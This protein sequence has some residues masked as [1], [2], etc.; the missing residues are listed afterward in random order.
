MVKGAW[1]KKI[2]V[3]LGFASPGKTRKASPPRS[4]AGKAGNSDATAT[5][6]EDGE[7]P[8]LKSK[9]GVGNLDS[10]RQGR[11]PFDSRERELLNRIT[12]RVE[13]GD[14]DLPHLPA[15]G[16]ALA[17][18]AGKP[19]VEIGRV[20]ELISSD[21]SLASELLRTA[22]SVLYATHVPAETLNEAVMR[23]G[24]RGLR[25]MIFSVSVKG[26]MLRVR[27]LEAYSQEIWRQAYSVAS[28]ARRI[29]PL[30]GI[31]KEHAFL[32]GLLHDVG[33]IVLLSMLSKEAKEFGSA[34]PATVGAVFHV[35]HER[36]GRML[37]ERWR[38]S[39]EIISVA[40][41]HHHF[42]ENVDYGHSAALASLSHKLDLHLS[43]DDD[44]GYRA[45]V[46]CD[47]FDYLGVPEGRR[48]AVLEQARRCF[49]DTTSEA[50]GEDP[51]EARA[52]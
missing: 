34:S 2:A 22:N 24:L 36:A 52:A 41:N 46:I 31:E 15:T 40:G 43:F 29:A 16:M 27:G 19:G 48:G 35:H 3:F 39:E 20:V 44:P 13:K 26:T 37:G 4:S 9:Q 6:A 45:L 30:V 32:V 10:P 47:E 7:K 14:F 23:I 5:E 18:L 11:T 28:I 49:E 33:K 17:N 51:D 25:S 1:L 12:A 38:L 50:A 21:P 42:M 8:K